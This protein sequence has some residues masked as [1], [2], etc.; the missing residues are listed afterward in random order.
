MI[1]TAFLS[2]WVL[3]WF[4]TQQWRQLKQLA[5]GRWEGLGK[6]L[7][8]QL[9]SSRPG[10]LQLILA[11]GA[12]SCPHL[13]LQPQPAHTATAT[14]LQDRPRPPTSTRPQWSL[15]SLSLKDILNV[16]YIPSRSLPHYSG[17]LD[18][19]WAFVHD[20]TAQCML[21]YSL[22][23]KDGTE[24]PGFHATVRVSSSLVR[25][26]V[27]FFSHPPFSRPLIFF[28]LSHYLGTVGLCPHQTTLSLRGWPHFTFQCVW[29][30][31]L[32]ILQSKHWHMASIQQM[33]DE[34]RKRNT[35]QIANNFHLIA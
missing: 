7:S 33:S 1:T 9:W 23:G 2:H 34:W 15:S 6:E 32:L 21:V 14:R 26:C 17:L 18:I 10:N 20:T 8:F 22:P 30:F 13:K 4:V 24:H 28:Q 25:G 35:Y 31:T 19:A 12:C 27:L 5:T 3:G 11:S 29:V 16:N